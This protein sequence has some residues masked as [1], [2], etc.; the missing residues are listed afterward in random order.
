MITVLDGGGLVWGGAFDLGGSG[1]NF[2]TAVAINN[3]LITQFTIQA[4]GN[5]VIEDVA[6]IRLGGV[7]AI[8]EPAT[9]LMMILG[10]GMVGAGLRTMRRK[11]ELVRLA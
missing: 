5:T 8:P 6:Q 11:E 7:S 4:L 10:F 2:F 9:W 3:Q 1:S